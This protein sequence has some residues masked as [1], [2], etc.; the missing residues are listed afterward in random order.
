MSALAMTKARIET[1]PLGLLAPGETAEVVEVAGGHGMASHL[2]DMGLRPGKRL[3]MLTNEGRGA[4]VVR[5][6]ET[7]IA[8]G[9]GL[10]M[11]VMVS[12]Q[13]KGGGA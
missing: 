8:I 13:D 5:V 9:R 11:K 6:E 2:E 12:R 3:E 1:L 10:A 4:M 7:R